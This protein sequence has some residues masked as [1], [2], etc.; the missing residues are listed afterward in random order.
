MKKRQIWNLI[1][2]AVF[3]ATFVVQVFAM[4]AIL[5]LDMLPGGL[6]AL[7]IGAFVVYDGL[8]AYFMFL[9]GKKVPKNMIKRTI[10]RRRII[11][12]VLAIVMICGCVVVTTVVN[13]VRKTFEAVQAVQPEL[14]EED[15]GITRTVY[16]RVHDAAQELKDA[17]DYTFGIIEGYDDECTRQAITAIENELGMGIRTEKFLNAYEVAAGLLSGRLDA[18]IINSGF[19]SILEEDSRYE[20][21]TDST[22][23]LAEVEIEGTGEELDGSGLLLNAEADIAENGKL[24]PFI[25]YVSG[26]DSRKGTLGGSTRSDVNILV[27]VNPETRQVLLLN[28]PRDT[29]VPNPH[30]NGEQDKLA[31][32]SIWGISNSI[33]ALAQLYDCEVQYY[34]QI[35]FAGFSKLIDAI[36]GITVESN[37]EFQLHN[38]P[39]VIKKGKNELDGTDALAFARTRK[40]L[41]GGDNDRGKNQMKVIKAILEKATSGTTIITNYAAIMESID[42]MFIMNVPMS[43]ISEVVKRQFSDMSGWNI[44]SYATSGVGH[45]RVC[46]SSQG[47]K[48]SVIEPKQES[49]DK[50]KILIKTV[51]DGEILTD[52]LMK[53]K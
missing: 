2:L 45:M 52:E 13:D 35:S 10:K 26:S 5:R 1:F 48:M 37:V 32:C 15:P 49:I 7:L 4:V 12:C 18:V 23:V 34:A 11:S 8:M 38:N 19:V 43:L 53:S 3:A 41:S 17:K 29:L 36:G 51:L 9:R 16:V 42:G 39:T 28:T 14:E 30:G 46:Y 44:Q 6:T 20:M 24:K 50:A 31:H 27:V 40:A 25:M 33:G 21:F 47:L 22:R